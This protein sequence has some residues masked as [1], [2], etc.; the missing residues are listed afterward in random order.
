MAGTVVKNCDFAGM[1]LRNADLSNA[2]FI[3]DDFGAKP[4]FGLSKS[5][6]DFTNAD[7]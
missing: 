3:D 5:P 2:T 7:L 6:P 1:I 4:A